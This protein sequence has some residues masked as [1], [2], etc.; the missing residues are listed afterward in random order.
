M[1][2]NEIH[3]IDLTDINIS[4]ENVRQSN[5]TQGV[6]ELAASIKSLGLLQPVVLL[7]TFGNPPYEL[8]AGQRRYLAHEKLRKRTIRAIFI[9]QKDK[10]QATLLSLV[11]NLQTVELNHADISRAVT[12]L[13]QKFGRDDTKVQKATG[14]SIRKIRDYIDI[15]EQASPKMKKMLHQ[16]K[17]KTA[18]V[19]RALRAAQGEIKKAERLLEFM[20]EFPLTKH[21]KR[22]IIEFGESDADASAKK[23]FEEAM[24]PRV[25]RSIIV[26]LPDIVR[27]GLEK[28]TKNMAKEPEEIVSDALREWLTTQGFIK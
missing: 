12:Y 8:I 11:E 9:G 1:V 6:D 22:R 5:E 24:K 7:G 26:S 16:G 3:E 13:Y 25:E 27:E 17:V 20:E 19:K 2:D 4:D 14:L 15:E 23:I 18:D 28:A 10:I 21:Q